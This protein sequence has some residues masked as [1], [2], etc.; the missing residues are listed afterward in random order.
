[1]FAYV[2]MPSH[3]HLF[4]EINSELSLKGEL[5]KLKRWTGRRAAEIDKQFQGRRFWQTEWFDHWSRSDEED[6][7]IARYIRQNPVKAGLV[8]HLEQWPYSY[9]CQ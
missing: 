1:M 2:V 9:S 8:D 3:I 4:F 7:Q 5:E 6:E